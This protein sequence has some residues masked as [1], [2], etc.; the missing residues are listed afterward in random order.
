MQSYTYRT[1]RDPINP[2]YDSVFVG[3]TQWN[4]TA[5][6]V[7]E[8]RFKNEYFY[9]P[10]I[11]RMVAIRDAPRFISNPIY[12]VSS[13]AS[14]KYVPTRLADSL[15]THLEF[16]SGRLTDGKTGDKLYWGG[17]TGWP[18]AEQKFTIIFDLGKIT[19]IFSARII[20]FV[21]ET[22]Q[23][24]IPKSV[25]FLSSKKCEPQESGIYSP[26]GFSSCVPE[27]SITNTTVTQFGGSIKKAMIT[28]EFGTWHTA[29]YLTI[30]G[31]NAGWTLMDEIEMYDN[32]GRLVSVGKPYR[33]SPMTGDYRIDSSNPYLD[34][35]K[36]TV[37]QNS[38]VRYYIGY[39]GQ[40][41]ID[42]FFF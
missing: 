36:V 27:V 38:L 30:T 9:Y 23:V 33:V 12:G 37:F 14:R 39:C 34:N 15:E 8:I 18:L 26:S 35:S 3:L 24:R 31:I 16:L 5:G 13:T 6:D 41:G 2:D 21:D 20:L 40:S 10:N 19:N 25:A 1:S 11:V 4:L 28:A 7:L 17:A 22:G 32:D 29:R 42:K